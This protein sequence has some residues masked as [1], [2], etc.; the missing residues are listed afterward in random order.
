MP[1]LNSI[2][3]YNISEI[4]Q[5]KVYEII[6]KKIYVYCLLGYKIYVK[7]NNMYDSIYNN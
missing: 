4:T 5:T 2:E 1:L 7:T 3:I 6:S